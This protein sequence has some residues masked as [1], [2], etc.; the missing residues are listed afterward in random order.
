MSTVGT[1]QLRSLVHAGDAIGR[2]LEELQLTVGEGPCRDACAGGPVLVADLAAEFTRWPV[3]GPAAARL[4]VAAVFSFPLRRRAVR[5]GSLDL[6][7]NR[8]GALTRQQVADGLL[9]AGLATQA[10]AGR[11]DGHDGAELTWPADVHAEV[12][13]AAGMVSVQLRTTTDAALLR[14]RGQAFLRGET[15]SC[16]A[17]Q[18]V[19]RTLRFTPS[20]DTSG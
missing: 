10:V 16:V 4:G 19:A 17:H 18:V 3:F 14:L 1:R 11:L 6:H 20:G 8:P 9:L 5:L 13:Q 15:L 12:H 2:A 7:R